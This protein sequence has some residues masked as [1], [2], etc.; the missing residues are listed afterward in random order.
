MITEEAVEYENNGNTNNNLMPRNDP[1]IP[2]KEIE[3]TGDQRKIIQTIA[4]INK[5]I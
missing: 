4:L 3:V 5:D 1:Q 2:R